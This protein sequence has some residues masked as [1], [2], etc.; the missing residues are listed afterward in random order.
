MISA[1]KLRAEVGK[2]GWDDRHIKDLQSIIDSGL[3]GSFTKLYIDASEFEECTPEE[4]SRFM[5]DAIQPVPMQTFSPAAAH[6]TAPRPTTKRTSSAN[7]AVAKKLM[8]AEFYTLQEYNRIM[9]NISV[10]L[11]VVNI[12]ETV[13]DGHDL[14]EVASGLMGL[15]LTDLKTVSYQISYLV[16]CAAQSVIDTV[17]NGDKKA[18]GWATY[19]GSNFALDTSAIKR[20]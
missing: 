7:P 13:Q 8:G 10:R 5:T 18:K 20:Y 6:T 19:C 14:E 16:G 17:Y 4:H 2:R 12:E 11:G 15:F 1:E 3:A 9:H